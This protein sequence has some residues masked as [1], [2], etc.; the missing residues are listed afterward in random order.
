MGE[1][2]TESMKSVGAIDGAVEA[3]QFP[4]PLPLRSS[5]VA[6]EA[7]VARDGAGGG[8]GARF[9]SCTTMKPLSVSMSD[10]SNGDGGSGGAVL[11]TAAASAGDSGTG[12]PSACSGWPRPRPRCLAPREHTFAPLLGL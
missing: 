6:S 7:A 8:G 9:F 1:L 11:S 12:S 3:A 5:P 2:F 10:Q 4:P